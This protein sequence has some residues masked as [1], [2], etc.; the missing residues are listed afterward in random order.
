MFSIV[1]GPVF[2]ADIPIVWKV[3]L[4]FTAAEP[5]KSHVHHFALSR[6]NSVVGNPCNSRVVSLDRRFGWGQPMPIRVWRCGMISRAVMNRAASSDSAAEAMT[7]KFDDLGNREDC[8][9]EPRE[10]IVF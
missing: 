2:R 1:I 10:V 6:N 4:G 3:V 7:D 8:T 9:I 5:P